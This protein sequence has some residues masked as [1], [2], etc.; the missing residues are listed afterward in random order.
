M[1]KKSTAQ[2]WQSAARNQFDMRF[3]YIVQQ[4]DGGEKY[5][6]DGFDFGGIA[7]GLAQFNAKGDAILY[8]IELHRR[9]NSLAVRVLNARDKCAEVFRREAGEVVEESEAKDSRGPVVLWG[10]AK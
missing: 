10:P 9:D 5:G 6:R 8:A 4:S 7:G 2:D 3:P 1:A